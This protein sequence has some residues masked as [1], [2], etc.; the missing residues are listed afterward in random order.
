M[1]ANR[2]GVKSQTYQQHPASSWLERHWTE[3]MEKKYRNRWIAVDGNGVVAAEFSLENLDSA[4]K[5]V[6]PGTNPGQFL[7][8]FISPDPL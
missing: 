6:C 2:R 8:A 4:L 3:A 1:A 5:I 7:T